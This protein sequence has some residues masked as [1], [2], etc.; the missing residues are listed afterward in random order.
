MTFPMA[1][2]VLV[3]AMASDKDHLGFA[4]ELISVGKLDA[5]FLTEVDI[6]GDKSRITSASSL[7]DCWVRASR[8]VGVDILDHGV[9]DCQNLLDNPSVCTVEL[10]RKIILTTESSLM[11]SL[12]VGNQILRARK[13]DQLGTIVVTGSLHIVSSVLRF[14]QG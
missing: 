9:A 7:K 3:V 10:E 4:R 11:N 1:R 6:A 14:I 2:M 12:R 5:V 8:E 13:G